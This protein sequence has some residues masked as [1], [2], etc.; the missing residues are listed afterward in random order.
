MV[1]KKGCWVIKSDVKKDKETGEPKFWSD[2]KGWVDGIEA[3]MYSTAEKRKMP[4]TPSGS[5]YVR[6][7]KGG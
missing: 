7:A 5:R 2:E 6:C 4:H 3:T 1:R